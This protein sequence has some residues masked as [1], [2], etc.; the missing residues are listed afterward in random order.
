MICTDGTLREPARNAGGGL[1]VATVTDS[2]GN[3]PG[4]LHDR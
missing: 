1:L 2:D 4:L 3:G